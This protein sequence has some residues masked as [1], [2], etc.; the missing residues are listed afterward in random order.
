MTTAIIDTLKEHMPKKKLLSL[1]LTS[2]LGRDIDP[3]K[4]VMTDVKSISGGKI[5]DFTDRL[6][7][8]DKKLDTLYVL[9]GIGNRCEDEPFAIDVVEKEIEEF[10]ALAKTKATSVKVGTIPP[11]PSRSA[12]VNQRIVDINVKLQA[13]CTA[14][15][16][17]LV[18]LDDIFYNRAGDVIEGNYC[19]RL[20]F[21]VAGTDAVAKKLGLPIRD[22]SAHHWNA[23][24]ERVFIRAVDP[25][26]A[27]SVEQLV[28]LQVTQQL[29][30]KNT[31]AQQQCGGGRGG[32]GRRAAPH[33]GGA[34][35]QGG[36]AAQQGGALGA[37]QH[38]G[39]APVT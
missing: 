6:Q 26:D 29:A 3:A 25:D 30:Q 35:Q 18:D 8:W 34:A 22:K 1:L 36:G 5:A 21:S 24:R 2:S 15:G 14:A 11:R 31:R 23:G 32:G 16:V 33:G 37:A 39:G 20:H 4:L 10:L 19:D 27:S 9:G 7:K 17:T 38:G 28:A 12:E 13:L